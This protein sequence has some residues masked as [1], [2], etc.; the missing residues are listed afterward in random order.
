MNEYGNK[1]TDLWGFRAI[2]IAEGTTIQF[3]K[4]DDRSWRNISYNL[5]DGRTKAIVVPG[6][7]LRILRGQGR[8]PEYL[9]VKGSELSLIT[10]TIVDEMLKKLVLPYKKIK[11]YHTEKYNYLDISNTWLPHYLFKNLLELSSKGDIIKTDEGKSFIQFRKE[12]WQ[13]AIKGIT[14]YGLSPEYVEVDS[15]FSLVKQVELFEMPSVKVSQILDHC[16]SDY[17]KKEDR[18]HYFPTDL[19]FPGEPS[20]LSEEVKSLWKE[21]EDESQKN[22]IARMAIA[23]LRELSWMMIDWKLLYQLELPSSLVGLI[24]SVEVQGFGQ[25]VTMNYFKL[26]IPSLG[27]VL[28]FPTTLSPGKYTASQAVPTETFLTKVTLERWR[29]YPYLGHVR[30]TGLSEFIQI[31]KAESEEKDALLIHM[32]GFP[33]LER[34]IAEIG[35]YSNFSIDRNIWITGHHP[36]SRTFSAVFQIVTNVDR[37]SSMPAIYVKDIV[38]MNFR[39]V[40]EYQD[41]RRRSYF[42]SS[43][44]RGDWILAVVSSSPH[45]K[46]ESINDPFELYVQPYLAINKITQDRASIISA[47]GFLREFGSISEEST[48]FLN[49][50]WNSDMN[51]TKALDFLSNEKMSLKREGSYFYVPWG[52]HTN[53]RIAVP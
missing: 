18:I 13:A 31:E 10:P 40:F 37:Y 42:L 20:G 22:P 44:R 24:L 3:L 33:T 2:E 6:W 8:P 15:G 39:L 11:V 26:F 9:M 50:E 17:F 5:I 32:S 47:L 1:D 29:V 7:I 43:L 46:N 12:D 53:G 14:D 34:L 28:H 36:F 23:F 4:L 45:R 30:N 49:S 25:N 51:F 21:L 48:N 16:Y 52:G 19:S 27:A 38:G 41:Y 35:N